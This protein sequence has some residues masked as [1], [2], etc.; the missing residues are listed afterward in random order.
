MRISVIIPTYKRPRIL[1]QALRSLQE[2]TLPDFEIVVVDNAADSEVEK[3]V[4]EFNLTAEH[5][6]CHVSEP[7]LGLHNA[8]L[9]MDPGLVDPQNYDFALT[10]SFPARDSGI[11]LTS[12]FGID[13]HDAADASLPAIAAPVIHTGAWDRGAYEYKETQT[14]PHLRFLGLSTAMA[15]MKSSKLDWNLSLR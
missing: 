3:M 6:G 15:I 1:L 2:Q 7:Q 14:P 11:D 8:D 4:A 12:V 10:D 13:N 9:V 5:L